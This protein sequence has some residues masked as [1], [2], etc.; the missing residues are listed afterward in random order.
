MPYEGME[1]KAMNKRSVDGSGA[2]N[3]MVTNAGSERSQVQTT[4]NGVLY[5]TREA[6]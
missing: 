1:D 6:N 2:I 5:C 3:F 4:G